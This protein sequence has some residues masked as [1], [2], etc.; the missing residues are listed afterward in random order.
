MVSMLLSGLIHNVSI[1][2]LCMSRNRLPVTN[3]ISLLPVPSRAQQTLSFSCA[4][5]PEE[6]A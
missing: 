1:T 6:R 4:C 3:A 2:V 5:T